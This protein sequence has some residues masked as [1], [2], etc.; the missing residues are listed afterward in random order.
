MAASTRSIHSRQRAA[1]GRS[2][3]STSRRSSPLSS[4]AARRGAHRPY[5]RNVGRPESSRAAPSATSRS[6]SRRA[7]RSVIGA[8]RA[9]SA[10]E[11]QSSASSRSTILAAGFDAQFGRDGDAGSR[12]GGQRSAARSRAEAAASAIAPAAA[13][14]QAGSPGLGRRPPPGDRRV[15]SR[16]FV[17]ISGTGR[18]QRSRMART[19]SNTQRARI[20]A[21][22]AGASGKAENARAAALAAAETGSPSPAQAFR[23]DA[24]PFGSGRARSSRA[25]ASAIRPGSRLGGRPA[26]SRHS[27]QQLRRGPERVADGEAQVAQRAFVGVEAQDLGGGRGA[28][29]REAGAQR[30]GG[31]RVAAQEGVEQSEAGAGG[32][33]R[34]ALPCPSARPRP[35]RDR[36]RRRKGL[37]FR[38]FRRA[39]LRSRRASRAARERAPPSVWRRVGEQVEIGANHVRMVN[40][41]RRFVTCLCELSAPLVVGWRCPIRL[42]YRT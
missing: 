25:A 39:P 31:G 19:M 15:G 13:F 16:I 18:G 4:A 17:A 37:P 2:T 24:R 35:G 33:Q 38:G 14:G 41:R 26:R 30:P 28:L 7:A 3:S 1:G 21:S 40:R 29:K 23:L 5:S 32:E 22:A 27:R 11:T 8:W 10:G 42:P 34:I 9:A 12:S 36:R 6:N 20:S